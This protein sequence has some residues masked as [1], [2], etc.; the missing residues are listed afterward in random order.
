MYP[1]IALQLNTSPRS[2]GFY[3]KFSSGPRPGCAPRMRR[4]CHSVLTPFLA[5]SRG[6]TTDGSPAF[7]GW[8][9]FWQGKRGGAGL[10]YRERKQFLT[11]IAAF[12]SSSRSSTPGR[13]SDGGTMR[14]VAACRWPSRPAFVATI[15]VDAAGGDF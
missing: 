12:K 1:R 3:K 2:Y 9:S 5:R 13:L 7:Q 4:Q 11:P 8:D 14:H 10:F 15:A 6:A